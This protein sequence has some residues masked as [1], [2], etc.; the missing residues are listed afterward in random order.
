[1]IV[2]S[3]SRSI[4]V[5]VH[6]PPFRRQQLSIAAVLTALQGLGLDA[7]AVFFFVSGLNAA[8]SA[9]ARGAF[10]AAAITTGFAVMVAGAYLVVGLVLCL[11]A[12]GLWKRQKWA[13]WT[14]LGTQGLSLLTM[15]SVTWIL[16]DK[17]WMIIGPYAFIALNL[18]LLVTSRGWRR[19]AE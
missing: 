6:T 11:S 15:I 16:A 19:A 14:A 1:V 9:R 3:R 17:Y 2:I 8:F 7:L 18:S 12:W 4:F 10:T 13:F 5:Q